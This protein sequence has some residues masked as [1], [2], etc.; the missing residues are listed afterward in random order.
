[1]KYL[2][3]PFTFYPFVILY[4]KCFII[5]LFRPYCIV[6]SNNFCLL[7]MV[8]TSFSC[9]VVIVTYVVFKKFILT[10]QFSIFSSVLCFLK[11]EYFY[12]S[13]LFLLLD[14]QLIH[15]KTYI[16]NAL[17]FTVYICDI[18]QPPNITISFHVK[19]KQLVPLPLYLLFYFLFCDCHAFYF[20]ICYN[21]QSCYYFCFRL[22]I[23]L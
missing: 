17:G 3:H 20:C 4:L 14:Y 2:F 18:S 9:S 19:F 12:D 5:S 6:Q 13:I 10:F 23:Y 8:F 21:P 16:V 11:I 1:M 22:S 7:I 15:L